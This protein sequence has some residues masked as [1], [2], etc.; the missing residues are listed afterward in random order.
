[1]NEDVDRYGRG[2]MV[3]V[4]A[5]VLAA[6]VG[7][8]ILFQGAPLTEREKTVINF[9]DIS[10]ALTAH[11]VT[12]LV[13]LAAALAIGFPLGILLARRRGVLRTVVITLANLT[14][15]IPSVSIL[16]LAYFLVG[17]GQRTAIY[18]LAA[19]SILPILRNTMVGISGVDPSV[20]EAARGMGMSGWESLLHIELPLASPVIFAGIRTAVVLNISSATLATF[21]GGGGLGDVI[22]SGVDSNLARVTLV[23]ATLVA[24]LAMLA[25]WA[26]GLLETRLVP[27]T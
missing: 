19:F 15:A 4:P 11:I 2:R 6:L 22:A 7:L 3:A 9:H 5:L 14:Q 21:I 12:T 13:A 25:D 26:F 8:W 1:V 27:R 20:L 16:I 23:G 18:A 24:S 17:S 10:N